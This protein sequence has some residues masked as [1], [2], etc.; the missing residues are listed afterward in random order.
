[1]KK[2]VGCSLALLVL[3]GSGTSG[4][5]AHGPEKTSQPKST[6]QN[7]PVRTVTGTIKAK[8]DGVPMPG[9]NIIVKGTQVGTTTDIQGRYAISVED[10]NAVLIFSYIG[11][12]SQEVPVNGKSIIDV[13]LEENVA[14]LQEAV[15]TAL[16]IKREKRSLGYSVG[17]VEGTSLT[18]T[19]QNNVL[20]TLAGKV[21]GVQI[22]QMSGAAGSSVS[23]I[24]RGANSLNSDNQPLFVIDGVPVANRMANAFAG[25]DMGNPI[26]DINP[27]DIANVSILKGPS[28]A[29]LYGSRAGN[30]VVLITTKSGSGGKK[31][32]GVSLNTAVVV[33][34]PLQYVQVQNKFGSGKTGA[35]VLEQEENESW[36]AALDK[37]EMWALW[38]TNGQKVPLVSYPN[39]F[40]DFF[41]TGVTNTNNVSVNGNYD[42]GN[43][44]LSVGNML[45]KG[46]VPN[47]DF[48]RL[49]LALNTTYNLSDKLRASVNFNVTESGSDNRPILDGSR[50]DPV[51]SIYETGAQVDINDLRDYWLPGQE[52][53]AQRKYKDKQ[54]NPFYLVHENP[55]GFKRDRT[56]S[57]IQLD[58]DINESFALTGRFSRDSYEEIQEAKKAYNNFEALKGGYEIAN[59]YRKEGNLDLILSY[60]KTFNEDWSLN[61]LAGVNRL[62][63]N[64]RGLYN[65]TSELVIP[66]LY[67][68]S[69]GAPG[70]ITNRSELS[71]KVL[72]GVYGSASVGFKDMVYLDLTARNDWTSTLRKGN[73]SYFYPSAS[74]SVLVSEMVPMPSWVSFAKL[75]AG[76]AQVGNDVAPY[77]LIQTYA[78]ALDWGTAKRMFM[79]GTLRNADLKPEISTS[80][81]IGID[82]KFLNNRLGLEA[83]YYERGNKNQ[84]LSI[85]TPIES[86]ASSKQINAGLVQS[87]G[88]ELGI[89]TTPIRRENFSWDM[90]FTLTR[91]R[92]YIKRLAEGIKYFAFTS[93]SG[94]EVRTYEGGQI[95]DIYMAPM[96]TVKDQTSPYYGY[97]IVTSG[98]LYQTD[99]D[100]NNLTK[101]G[102]FNHNF[103]MGIQPSITYK[104]FTLY[105]NID[106][107]QGGSFFSNTMMF[108]GNNGQLE[109]TISGVPYDPNRSLSEQIKEN[110]EMYLGNW[111]GG[112]NAEYG[113]FP[114]PGAEANIRVQDASLN[115]GVFA[116]KDA[117]GNTVYVENL[118][119]A[120]SKWLD[121]FSAYRYSHRPFP[122]RNLYS[123]TYVKL[124]E[125]SVSYHLPKSFVSRFKIQN[126]SLAVVGNNLF[127]WTKAGIEGLDPERAFRQTGGNWTQGVEYYNVMPWTGSLGFRLNVDF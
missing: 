85:G 5:W 21:A 19:P 10:E 18:Q 81:E 94:A 89:M 74:L 98:G 127:M 88:F 126:A 51:R 27:N 20:N 15:V 25:A 69:N 61:A 99:N 16:G 124:R 23:M 78:T 76:Y 101:I 63:Q 62:E 38:N 12:N 59:N 64:Y 122:D 14:T 92:T 113:G 13:N 83:T 54:N 115:P 125:V 35:H 107:R 8:A 4:A 29:A 40:K 73:N 112:R 53:L 57:K 100:V 47:T 58:Y 97:P 50:N 118:G 96:L 56:V 90:N 104:N 79:G 28:A 1:M 37:G 68:I 108:L 75:R 43:F 33:D 32:I 86:G 95:G 91:N 26:A 46:V 34:K 71:R 66:G 84:I 70:T 41:Q 106:W 72:Y 48:S 65:S 52:G 55:T 111:V 102:N 114:W 77:S 119:D 60:K 121:P 22:S 110:P 42:K 67:T 45:N 82:M 116:T 11:F 103:L 123:A 3:A 24:I 7:Q 2:I 9:V 6:S 17:N 80:H 93:Y 117:A 36:G 39:R 120:G 109:E 87:K 44:R 30:G 105:A 49:T 31:G